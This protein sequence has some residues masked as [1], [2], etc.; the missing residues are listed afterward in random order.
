[1]LFFK[2]IDVTIGNRVS[3]EAELGGLDIPEMG[4]LAYPDFALSR[5][6]GKK[7]P[8]VRADQASVLA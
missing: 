5:A 4:M 2:L 3:A 7:R 1:M 8:M 6:S